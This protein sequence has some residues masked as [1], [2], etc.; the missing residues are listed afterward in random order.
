MHLGRSAS[1]IRELSARRPRYNW[2]TPL[3]MHPRLSASPQIHPLRPGPLVFSFSIFHSRFS[4]LRPILR[5]APDENKSTAGN[6]LLKSVR[7]LK[8]SVAVNCSRPQ[9]RENRLNVL[10][11]GS[12]SSFRP[13]LAGRAVACRRRDRPPNE[14]FLFPLQR[15][16]VRALGPF[17]LRPRLSRAKNSALARSPSPQYAESPASGRRRSTS[18][19]LTRFASFDFFDSTTF[20]KAK[21]NWSY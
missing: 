1:N 16:S 13:C 11:A 14:R 20:F 6:E 21:E 4:S 12:F 17:S 9:R 10:R 7:R 3:C 19:R 15:F 18:R 2:R 8:F 5:A